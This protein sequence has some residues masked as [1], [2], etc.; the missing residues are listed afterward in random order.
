[1]VEPGQPA[2]AKIAEHFGN[3]L[4]TDEGALDRTA[5]RHVVFADPAER[6]WLQGLL[7]PLITDYLLKH[8]R[9]A[10]SPYA[11]LV[12]PLLLETQQDAW[13]QAVLVIDVPESLQ[14]TRTMLRDDNTREQV[15]NIMSAQIDRDTRLTRATDIIVNDKDLAALHAKVDAI[16]HKYLDQ[17]QNLLA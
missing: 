1:V 2:L 15:E 16:H 11:V 6:K 10:T 5:L 12:N 14:I 13:C 3:D 9:Q 8:I 7:H 4:I 17:C